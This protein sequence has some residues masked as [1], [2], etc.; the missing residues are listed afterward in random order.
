MRYCS[1]LEHLHYHQDRD[2]GEAAYEANGPAGS[3]RSDMPNRCEE[4]Y[5]EMDIELMLACVRLLG[6]DKL[7]PLLIAAGCQDPLGLA[8]H[9]LDRGD[10]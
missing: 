1:S 10:N 5:R 7:I 2:A 6:P 4:A 9:W 8:L 3:V